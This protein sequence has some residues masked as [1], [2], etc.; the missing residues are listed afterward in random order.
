MLDASLK[1]Q[2]KELF[3]SLEADYLFDIAVRSGHGSRAELLELLGDTA[4]ASDRLACRVSEGPG[5]EFRILKNGQELGIRFS[6]K[7]C[8]IDH[9]EDSKDVIQ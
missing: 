7:Q 9:V 8:F 5:L 3:G 4:A 2:L 1:E 6:R